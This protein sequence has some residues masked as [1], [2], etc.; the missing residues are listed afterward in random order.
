[1]PSRDTSLS[2]MAA[3]SPLNTDQTDIRWIENARDGDLESFGALVRRYE[4]TV[5]GYFRVRLRDWAAADDLAQDVFVTAF[6]RIREF[7]GDSSFATWLR[8]IALN[9]LRNYLRKH[10]EELVGGTE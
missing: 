4:A 1:M 6:R 3:T 5:R 8:S 7:R 2:K 9:H 10:R